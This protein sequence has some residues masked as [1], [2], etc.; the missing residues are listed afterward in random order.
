MVSPF[1][2]GKILIGFMCLQVKGGMFRMSENP[3]RSR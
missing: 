3:S 1:V 2:L